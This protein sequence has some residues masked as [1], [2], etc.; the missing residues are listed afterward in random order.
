ME[1][2]IFWICLSVL[3]GVIASHKGRSGWW[4]FFLSVLLSPLVGI[5]AALVAREDT[6]EVESRQLASGDMR[7]CPDC[8]ELIK[9]ETTVCRYCGSQNRWSE[10]PSE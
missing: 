1:V 8:A 6:W 2:F 7:K 5:I 3:A 10:D 4:F 9:R